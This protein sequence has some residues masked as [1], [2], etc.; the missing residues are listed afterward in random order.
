MSEKT[1]AP[2]SRRISEARQEG[3]VARSQELNAA[4]ALLIGAW[5]ITGPGKKLLQDL[6]ELVIQS[7]TELPSADASF[8]WVTELIMKDG[9]RVAINMGVILVGL[10]FTGVVVTEV[11]TGLL[12]S[13][14]RIGFDSSRVNPL[15]GFKRMFSGQGLFELGKALIKLVVIG[16]AAYNFLQGRKNELLGLSQTDFM[17]AIQDWAVMASQLVIR[18]GGI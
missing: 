11:Q 15:N 10:L 9:L 5:L 8:T 18:V 2:T 17:S 3:R 13:T 1:E 14:K 6:M 4:A 7:I 12:W 16:L